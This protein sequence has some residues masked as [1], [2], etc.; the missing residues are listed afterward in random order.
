[1]RKGSNSVFLNFL[2]C[3]GKLFNQ[4]GDPSLSPALRAWPRL[5]LAYRAGAHDHP[6]HFS[7]R[8]AGSTLFTPA[9]DTDFRAQPEFSGQDKVNARQLH[10]RRNTRQFFT[11]VGLS[12][13][14][15]ERRSGELK[16]KLKFTKM[17]SA[18]EELRRA[19][20]AG[21]SVD[22]DD[23]SVRIG[24]NI[25]L[26]R[27][28]TTDFHSMRGR[29]DAYLLESIFFQFKFRDLHYNDYVQACRREGVAHV[30]PLDK[31]DLL[32]YLK[33]E[34]ATCASIVSKPSSTTGKV[35]SEKQ[36]S[37]IRA[38]AQEASK[39]HEDPDAKRKFSELDKDE[40]SYAAL[41]KRDRDQRA[42]DS[43]LMVTEWDFSTLREKLAQHVS[44]AKSGK[45]NGP[46]NGSKPATT[47][48]P[49]GDR[50]T[51]N[52]DR[53]WREN[54]GSEFHELGIDMSGS[55]KAKPSSAANG[56]SSEKKREKAES[57]RPSSSGTPS[58]K[59]QRI[60]P[61]ELVPIVI[62][63]QSMT[64][65]CAGNVVE[66]LQN[67]RFIS[68]EERK[69]NQ[70]S[71]IPASRLEMFRTPGG[72][73][74][75]ARY[76]IVTNTSRL[77]ESEWERVVAVVCSGQEWQFKKWQIYKDSAQELF[78]KV[79]G[80]YFHYDDDVPVGNVESW[81]IKKLKLS[82]SQRHTDGQVQYQFWNTFDAFMRRKGKELRY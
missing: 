59:R 82:R 48:D 72:N 23:S 36:S 70:V 12:F 22:I 67:G 13:S 25:R 24:E 38:S 4:L 64:L 61:K 39:P 5:P 66:F 68:A 76:D 17:A 15:P 77:S 30:T 74:S 8:W 10:F 29:G 33:G 56:P 55:F 49:R 62:V 52:E 19:I 31:K 75:R 79:Q 50:Y 43:V 18:L 58:A 69:K 45:S 40:S 80:F 37:A 53:F 47:Y 51:S 1:M 20:I 34:I 3:H 28:L 44:N 41:R 9:S 21:E 81:A 78:R 54:L 27:S 35:K 2:A 57:R 26:K 42:L 6:G 46:E 63:P 16:L 11:R 7:I 65:V 14:T 73:C 71:S 32:A 60:D